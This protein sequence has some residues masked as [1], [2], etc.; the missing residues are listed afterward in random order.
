MDTV[1]QTSPASGG[2]SLVS[3]MGFGT[4]GRRSLAWAFPLAIAMHLGLALV[5]NEARAAEG[6]IA[7]PTEIE[8]EP[9]PPAPPEPPPPP[10]APVPEEKAEPSAPAIAATSQPTAA[11]PPPAAKAGNVLTVPDDA[12]AKAGEEPVSFVTDPNGDSYGSGVVAKGGTAE[13]GLAGAKVGGTGT[14]AAPVAA[15]P[16]PVAA[17]PVVSS[18]DLSRPAKLTEI[19]PCRG[20]F[21]STADDDVGTVT[22]VLAI[23]KN[24]DVETASVVT[25]SPKG[26]GFGAAARACLLGKRFEP[27][28]D[29]SGQ[30][31]T[32]TTKV[33]IRFT[34]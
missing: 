6:P 29:K 23:K 15:A 30:P 33:N 14:V 12:P 20:R 19:D 18:V 34:R 2:S 28:F 9:P 24:G 4:K 26:Q 1:P 31:V 21:P 22:L 3:T 27:A 25:E 10:P 7:P 17:A 5:F 32:A 13:V 8:I 16:K 11:P